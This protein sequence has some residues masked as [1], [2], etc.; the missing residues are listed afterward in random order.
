[1]AGVGGQTT[2]ARYRDRLSE[3]PKMKYRKLLAGK[4][5]SRR[6][7][8]L[9][10]QEVQLHPQPHV[11]PR[12]L[13]WEQSLCNAGCSRKLKTKNKNRDLGWSNKTGSK[14]VAF[15]AVNPGLS[16]GKAY[17]PQGSSRSVIPEWRVKSKHSA[18]PNAPQ[19][20]KQKERSLQTN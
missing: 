20:R 6:E 7:L 16:L 4:W 15:H 11:V 12:V 5:L 18:L 9:C 2:L 14:A 19:K 10:M 17:G 8:G 13:N 1:M 3:G